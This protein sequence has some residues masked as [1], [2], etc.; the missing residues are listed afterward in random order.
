[1]IDRQREE[2]IKQIC[3][4]LESHWSFDTSGPIVMTRYLETH[5]NLFNNDTDAFGWIIKRDMRCTWSWWHD[6]VAKYSPD[7]KVESI[8][9]ILSQITRFDGYVSLMNHLGDTQPMKLDLA[10]HEVICRQQFGDAI[11]PIFYKNEY[12]LKV[13]NPEKLESRKV[14]IDLGKTR[15]AGSPFPLRGISH[16]GRQR[17][18][19]PSDCFVEELA[20]GNRMVVANRKEVTISREHFSVQLLTPQGRSDNKSEPC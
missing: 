14:Y 15:Q 4:E 6:L 17:S 1:M 20:V 2:E 3:D 19:D 18:R 9:N 7:D 16:F 10:Q 12:G 11:G 5:G 13:S 8:L